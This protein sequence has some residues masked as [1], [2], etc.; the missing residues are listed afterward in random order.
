MHIFLFQSSNDGK[1]AKINPTKILNIVALK[2]TGT[3]KL[4]SKHLWFNKRVGVLTK[5]AVIN[6]VQQK[7]D[8]CVDHS[9][10]RSRKTNETAPTVSLS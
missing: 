8:D 2:W 10:F 7:Q 5:S 1:F 3:F 6:L 4:C 9:L